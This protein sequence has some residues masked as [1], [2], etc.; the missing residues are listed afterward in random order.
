MRC[1]KCAEFGA[2]LGQGFELNFGVRGTRKWRNWVPNGVF[3]GCLV[4]IL[5]VCLLKILV[6]NKRTERKTHVFGLEIARYYPFAVF[7]GKIVLLC[8]KNWVLIVR[9][10][11]CLVPIFGKI[12]SM[13][14]AQA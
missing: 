8:S 5:L 4:P 2:G 6:C 7:F 3:L 12:A 1:I 14:R 10:R 9:K 11:G 13:W